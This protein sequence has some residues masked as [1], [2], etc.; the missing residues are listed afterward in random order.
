MCAHAGTSGDGM[1]RLGTRVCLEKM[2]SGS[3]A[4]D[5]EDLQGPWSSSLGASC[6][7]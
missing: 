2:A 1:G 5:R 6:I 3:Y 7:I 4:G